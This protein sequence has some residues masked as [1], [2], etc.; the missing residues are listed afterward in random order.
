MA[1]LYGCVGCLTAENGGFRPGQSF[2][3][4][5][6]LVA[7]FDRSLWSAVRTTISDEARAW[8]NLYQSGKSASLSSS[9]W[10]AG[11]W[12]GLAPTLWDWPVYLG[13][14]IGV[15]FDLLL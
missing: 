3:H 8:H 15:F 1:C 12:I 13:L 10:H 2:P 11:L 5:Q 4:A 6:L 14:D 7:S 9:P